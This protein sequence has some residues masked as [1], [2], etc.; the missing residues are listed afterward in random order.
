MAPSKS[1]RISVTVLGVPLMRNGFNLSVS[2][3]TTV[4]TLGTTAE[5]ALKARRPINLPKPRIGIEQYAL[6]CTQY[7][8]HD[9][10]IATR[11]LYTC[12]T[13]SESNALQAKFACLPREMS[14]H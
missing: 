8:N 9:L 6:S 10:R 11:M 3:M 5:L 7:Q 2:T 13:A 1:Y 12:L 4:S 14:R